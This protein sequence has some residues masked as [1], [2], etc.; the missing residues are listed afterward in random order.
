MNYWGRCDGIIGMTIL[1][2]RR[3]DLSFLG[4]NVAKVDYRSTFYSNIS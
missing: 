1:Q 4:N 3:F 2:D